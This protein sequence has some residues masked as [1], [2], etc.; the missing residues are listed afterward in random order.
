MKKIAVYGG[1][2]NPPHIGHVLAAQ[3]VA[4]TGGFDEVLV[5]PTYKHAAGKKLVDFYHRLKMC[6]LAF[7]S[8][9]KCIVD[10]I[11]ATLPGK[12]YSIQTLKALHKQ[13]PADY[14][15]VI[16]SDI[17]FNKHLWENPEEV[18]RLAPPFLIGRLG[19]PHPDAPENM[20]LPGV[21]STDVRHLLVDS[22]YG[23]E[24]SKIMPEN[25][26]EYIKEHRLYYDMFIDNAG[27][28]TQATGNDQA[29][30]TKVKEGE[31]DMGDLEDLIG[32]SS[33]MQALFD[34]IPD[35]VQEEKK[36][37]EDIKVDSEEAQDAAQ[38]A[39]ENGALD[40]LGDAMAAIKQKLVVD[41][42]D[43]SDDS[44]VSDDDS[45][46][47]DDHVVLTQQV[48]DSFT[49]E[50]EF[51]SNL[52][53]VQMRSSIA[54]EEEDEYG[55]TS[56]KS[57]FE[58]FNTVE[59]AFQAS[60]TLDRDIQV[61]IR[62]AATPKQAK[63]LGRRAPLINNWDAK[64]IDV[65]H[66]LL[67]DKF[68]QCFELKLKLLLTGDAILVQGNSDDFWGHDKNGN[69][70][71]HIGRLLMRVRDDI[72]KNEGSVIDLVRSRLEREKLGFMADWIDESKISLV[73]L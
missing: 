40:K 19:Y 16:G 18:F 73:S 52:F 60:K 33:G 48:I 31:E 30:P 67:K 10:P 17:M 56:V 32:D 36:D 27:A 43:T 69:G 72:L 46:T 53:E 38:V 44:D 12:S 41:V 39:V 64:R 14:R 62:D 37:Q 24:L 13:R 35:D 2:F 50:Y 11:E 7:S 47:S 9:P 45:D 28:K 57:E 34:S 51:L 25:V 49:G 65:M 5:I 15:F 3:Y 4:L 61:Q 26:L 42:V 59:H 66:R 70:T 21:S 68:E 71:N 29:Q 22:R 8:V 1:S 20:V 23:E 58:Y 6:Q 54:W 63:R 55:E